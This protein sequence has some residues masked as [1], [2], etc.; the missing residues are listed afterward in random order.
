MAKT[1]SNGVTLGFEQKLWQAANKL[2]SNMGIED[3]TLL[4]NV[5]IIYELSLA[6]LELKA[7]GID[8]EITNGFRISP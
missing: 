5:G 3:L 1:H 6:E 8:F 2:C 7:L 4:D